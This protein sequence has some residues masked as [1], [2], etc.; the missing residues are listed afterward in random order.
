MKLFFLCFLVCLSTFAQDNPEDYFE[1]RIY[2]VGITYSIPQGQ[3]LKGIQ[4]DKSAENAL[5]FSGSYLINPFKN[6]G[7][8]SLV[9]I[10]PEFNFEGLRQNTFN[11]PVNTDGFYAKHSS[12]SLRAK[13]KYVPILVSKKILPSLSF[14][15]GPRR[16]SSKLMEQIGEDQIQK[17][18]GIS[19][20]ALSYAF[21]AGIEIRRPG[22]TKKYGKISLA[23]ELANAVKTWNRDLLGFDP[24]Y[25]LISPVKVVSP[26]SIMLK[27]QLINYR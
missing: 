14:S 4:S 15:I 13:V 26:S 16:F 25:V 2:E 11:A 12:F 5:G 1:S 22:K 18:D 27:I 6:V 7:N 20:T 23:Y 10:G 24:Q 19:A 17:V 21:E 8:L 3:Y 9:F